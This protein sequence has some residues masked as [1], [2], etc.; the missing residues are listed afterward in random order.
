MHIRYTPP[1]AAWLVGQHSGLLI[2]MAQDA[3]E[4]DNELAATLSASVGDESPV[5]H[6][7]ERGTDRTVSSPAPVDGAESVVRLHTHPHETQVTFSTVDIMSF[8][9]TSLRETPFGRLPD[10]PHGYG[11][12]GRRGD[13]V[14]TLEAHIQTIE[15]TERWAHAGTVERD[16][17]ERDAT[18]RAAEARTED[19]TNPLFGVLG[20]Y[21]R[22]ASVEYSLDE[23]ITPPNTD[24]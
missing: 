20:P 8:V 5:L 24:R 15:P 12:I 9:R 17:V 6:G 3:Y 2:E 22:R 4:Q 23:P 10:G 13:D 11:V 16:R 7:P 21:I 1:L 19:E 14:A 18:Q